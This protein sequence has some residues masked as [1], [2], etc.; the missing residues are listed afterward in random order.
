MRLLL[1]T[2]AFLWL[3]AQPE[4]LSETAIQAINAPENILHLS[5]VSIWE[6][7]LKHSTGKLPLPEP[8]RI[9][10]PKQARFFHL[11][12]V[13][14][15]PEA[16]FKSGELPRTHQDPFDRLIAAQALNEPFHLVSPDEPF[17][18]YGVSCIW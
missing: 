1:D 11:F 12:R 4:K 9:W 13:K 3:A 5:D 14:I 7:S 16:L 2:C 15:E 10:V 6:I 18:A 8:P 17:R